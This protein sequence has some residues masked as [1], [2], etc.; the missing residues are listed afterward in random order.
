MPDAYERLF[1]DLFSGLQY[2]FVRA[3]ELEHA[4]RIFTPLLRRIETERIQPE[5]YIFG[6]LVIYYIVQYFL[7]FYI[8]VVDQNQVIF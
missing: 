8:K 5:K 6:R 7:I 4:W 1:F 3:D 2:N